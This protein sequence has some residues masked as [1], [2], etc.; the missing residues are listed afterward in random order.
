M[1]GG[2]RG[3]WERENKR[4]SRKGEETWESQNIEALRTR[5]KEREKKKPNLLVSVLGTQTQAVAVMCPSCLFEK[6]IFLANTPP[7]VGGAKPTQESGRA[8]RAAL[9]LN[10]LQRPADKQ[11]GRRCHQADCCSL[12]RVSLIW[13]QRGGGGW[14]AEMEGE[15]A[16]AT[17]G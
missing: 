12:G 10:Q 1:K 2:E 17:A 16:G 15:G 14:G 3:R 11:T 4:D 9:S 7:T 5:E 8:C 13:E 6:H